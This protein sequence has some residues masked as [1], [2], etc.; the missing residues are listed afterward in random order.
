MN[1]ILTENV[2]DCIKFTDRI[3]GEERIETAKT[4]ISQLKAGTEAF[5]IMSWGVDGNVTAGEMNGMAAAAFRV[6]GRL[7]PGHVMIAY[8]NAADLY[9]VWLTNGGKCKCLGK[10]IYCDMLGEVI[11]TAIERGTDP[12]E[13][14]RFCESERE[15]LMKDIAE[16]N[17]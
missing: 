11:D 15:K 8:D 16:G 3:N 9:E 14:E 13:Y 1:I 7:F 6:N 4:I 12:E 10:G 5:V 17:I 2:K